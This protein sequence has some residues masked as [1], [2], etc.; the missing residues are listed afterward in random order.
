[1]RSRSV[2]RARKPSKVAV[3]GLRGYTRPLLVRELAKAHRRRVVDLGP[4]DA[5]F[6]ARVLAAKPAVL[7]VDVSTSEAPGPLSEIR[8]AIGSIRIII[9]ADQSNEEEA[10]RFFKS[11]A[12]GFVGHETDL[13]HLSEEIHAVLRAEESEPCSP[14]MAKAVA[15]ASL[16]GERATSPTPFLRPRHR[17]VAQ[18][19]MQNLSN[20]EIADRL[21][22]K[23]G[24]V[25]NHVHQVLEKLAVRRRGDVWIDL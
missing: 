15:K 22:I 3:A 21:S 2:R 20:K 16:Q 8:R 13:P 5:A 10:S 6:V 18:L 4:V 24:T 17:Q 7:L 14:A 23:I 25:K 11:G 9:L 19:L 12:F 1:M